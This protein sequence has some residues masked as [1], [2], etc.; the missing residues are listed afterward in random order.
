MGGRSRSPSL[1]PGREGRTTTRSRRAIHARAK[2]A[3]AARVRRNVRPAVEE[4]AHEAHRHPEGVVFRVSVEP[5]VVAVG[6][7]LVLVAA[8]EQGVLVALGNNLVS[9]VDAVEPVLV[10][11]DEELGRYLRG[12]V[13]LS[14]LRSYFAQGPEVC[15][16]L[17]P[18]KV[19]FSHPGQA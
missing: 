16:A 19:L 18:H 17:A 9:A 10:P 11:F 7:D 6:R 2:A 13:V 4:V 1:M 5:V 14:Q 15:G 3:V 8:A 12:S